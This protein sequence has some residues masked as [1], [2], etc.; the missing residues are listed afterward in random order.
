[1]AVKKTKT[2]TKPK[3]AAAPKAKA[4]PKK[5]SP[6]PAAAAP[7]KKMV[8]KAKAAAPKAKAA[9]TQAKAAAPAA[10]KKA[11]KKA[12]APL[13]LT[14]PQS[15]LL[16]KVGTA[17]DTGY[18]GDK[19]LEVRTLEALRERK[20]VKK[21][22]KDKASGAFNYSVSAAGKKHLDTSASSTTS[23]GSGGGS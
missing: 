2:S 10:P 18:L 22:A 15:E 21:G 8:P 6:A 19:K 4:A 16:K 3:A 11:P 23:T 1:M 17:G 20:L 5:A 9:A 12:A 7:E 14:T 13:K